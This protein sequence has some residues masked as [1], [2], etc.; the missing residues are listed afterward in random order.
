MLCVSERIDECWIIV[1][2]YVYGYLQRGG[3]LEKMEM[4]QVQ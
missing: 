2:M 3:V 1:I 4:N